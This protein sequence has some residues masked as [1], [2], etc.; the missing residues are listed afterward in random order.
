METPDFVAGQ[1]A[2]ELWGADF[3]LRPGSGL[4][5]CGPG[6]PRGS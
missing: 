3:S 1:E 4:S 6:Q 5:R 2:G